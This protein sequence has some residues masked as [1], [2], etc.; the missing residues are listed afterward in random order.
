MSVVFSDFSARWYID[1]TLPSDTTV[2][3]VGKGTVRAKYAGYP[4]TPTPAYRPFPA[5]Y[6]TLLTSTSPGTGVWAS[7]VT[8]PVTDPAAL[9]SVG[10]GPFYAYFVYNGGHRVGVP[11]G[12]YPFPY[13]GRHT[14][15]RPLGAPKEIY[16]DQEWQ[17]LD[18][19]GVTSLDQEWILG[20]NIL[21]ETTLNQQWALGRAYAESE[22]NFKWA[23]IGSQLL[24]E[25]L[26]LLN[27]LRATVGVE[28][29][30]LYSGGS[31]DIAQR[32]SENMRATGLLEHEHPSFPVGWRTI[33]ERFSRMLEF[34]P[35]G[36]ENLGLAINPDGVLMA[37]YD[38]YDLWVN[39]PGHYANMV[40]DFGINSEVYMLFGV[41][42]FGV[43][44]GYDSTGLETF[45][46]TL[47]L[48]DVSLGSDLVNTQRE[49]RMQ[50]STYGATIETHTL[51]WSTF[52]YSKVTSSHSGVYSLRVAAQDSA[53]YGVGVA[54]QHIAPVFYT[55]QARHTAAYEPTVPVKTQRE[56]S[57][58]IVEFARVATDHTSSWSS[59]LQVAHVAL[60]NDNAAIRKGHTADYSDSSVIRKQFAAEYGPVPLVR[61]Q[62][63]TPYADTLVARRA[64]TASYD[65]LPRVILA[66]TIFYGDQIKVLSSHEGKYDLSTYNRVRKA[67]S[68]YY[69]INRGVADVITPT[70]TV[71]VAGVEIDFISV[72]VGIDDGDAVW[73]GS[74][75]VSSPGQYA[76]IE[77]EDEV[78]LVLSG[79][80][81]NLFV[82]AKSIDR[83]SPT[84]AAMKISCLSPAALQDEPY[85]TP[86]E[87]TQATS[88][89][90]KDLVESLLGQTVD[91]GIVDWTILPYRFAVK[92]QT[93]LAAARLVAEAAGGVLES[94]P[95]GTLRARYR[96]P[97][98]VPEFATTNPDITLSDLEDNLSSREKRYRTDVFDSFRLREGK[99]ILAD[100]LEWEPDDSGNEGTL[101]AYLT[102]WRQT[103]YV[104][105]TDD[106]ALPLS[107]VGV[108]AR[109]E[110]ETLEIIN[111]EGSLRYPAVSIES[112]V[113]ESD[114]LGTLFVEP[115]TQQVTVSDPSVNW[116]YG[117]VTVT[118][119]VETLNYRTQIP[120][121]SS[122]QFL[123]VDRGV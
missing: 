52:A 96:F 77:L 119:T 9:P 25:F 64:H 54:Y 81:Y 23:V 70:A 38:W 122:V 8:S 67:H 45:A 26:T 6:T 51:Q 88:V 24:H 69:T 76:A 60:Y 84:G 103:A 97:V 110:E 93:P 115:R 87:H 12:Q 15:G 21:Y 61:S 31:V 86:I 101:R 63:S 43:Y 56:G 47:N 3:P 59:A 57:Y 34:P 41:E 94:L 37:A 27:N 7:D 120:V 79:V 46:A 90:A 106:V 20:E 75:E 99:G 53:P 13:Y 30:S 104:E 32:H 28:P 91:W 48:F 118:Y 92:D 116:G 18:D 2:I 19:L 114:S 68:G 121:G 17:L 72:E 22:I 5:A 44:E 82:D 35:E 98:S 102:P 10:A 39:S 80:P 112:Y 113:W 14:I 74:I 49:L 55:V 58:D 105:H 62:L 111:G 4:E 50:W 33:P 78:A 36:N 71:T 29:V 95:D 1:G 85:A 73:S 40:Q 89:Q 107:L 83:D 100:S 66:H 123:I 109:T 42:P 108:V 65:A 16:L 117:L 11:V